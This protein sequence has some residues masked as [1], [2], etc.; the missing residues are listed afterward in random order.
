MFTSYV[1]CNLD[2]VM[3]VKYDFM[4]HI[5]ACEISFYLIFFKK[6]FVDV[7]NHNRDKVIVQLVKSTSYLTLI[8]L[9]AFTSNG[10]YLCVL[11]LYKNVIL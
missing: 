3:V 11:E 7:R 2:R 4:K 9:L 6:M 10:Y 8:I 5:F 1:N